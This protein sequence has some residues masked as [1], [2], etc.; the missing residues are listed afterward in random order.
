M[1]TA[2][3]LIKQAILERK[4]VIAKYH[5][6]HR[7]MCPHV[8]GRKNGRAKA[9]F[10]QFA[11]E[12]TSDPQMRGGWRDTFVDEIEIIKI[13]DGEWYTGPRHSRMQKAVDIVDVE[14]DY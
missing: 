2:Y 4:Q 3:D 1:N 11:G 14:I 12:S 8:I 13:R 9:L 10:W 6:K 5:G 7:E